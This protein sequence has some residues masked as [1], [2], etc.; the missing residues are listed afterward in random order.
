M[1][2]LGGRFFINL[3]SFFCVLI[4]G[5]IYVLFGSDVPHIVMDP[6]GVG[7]LADSIDLALPLLAVVYLRI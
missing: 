4:R 2:V 7:R 5:W 1:W 6:I 3:I